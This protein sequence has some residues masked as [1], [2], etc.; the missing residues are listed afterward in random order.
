VAALR[1]NAALG[2]VVGQLIKQRQLPQRPWRSVA[3]ELASS[4]LLQQRAD[5]RVSAL[6]ASPGL[7]ALA[8]G[9][10]RIGAVA[11]RDEDLGLGHR[12]AVADE[13]IVVAHGRLFYHGFKSR[14]LA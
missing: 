14:G 12:A 1:R 8:D 9:L 2:S 13:R 4:L 11:D 7:A 5:R 3:R 10:D 6:A